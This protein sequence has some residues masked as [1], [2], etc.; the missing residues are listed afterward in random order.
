MSKSKVSFGAGRKTFCLHRTVRESDNTVPSHTKW[1][2]Y[3][4]NFI[5]DFY[6]KICPSICDHI[7]QRDISNLHQ[8]Y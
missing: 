8:F 2:G 4:A 1:R 5:L 7:I 6:L 3:S